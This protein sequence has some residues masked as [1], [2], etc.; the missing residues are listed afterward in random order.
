MDTHN[1]RPFKAN[2]KAKLRKLRLDKYNA[3]KAQAARDPLHKGRVA[4]PKITREEVVDAMLEAWEELDPNLGAN[5]WEVV[6][7][8]PYELAQEKGWTPKEAFADIRHLDWPWQMVSNIKPKDAGS[9][10]EAFEWDNV[11]ESN[12]E[13]TATP[14]QVRAQMQVNAVPDHQSEEGNQ[15]GS[16]QTETETIVVNSTS[17]L[18]TPSLPSQQSKKARTS[19]SSRKPAPIFNFAQPPKIP[20]SKEGCT[21]PDRLTSSRCQSCS[22]PV[23]G[24]CLHDRVLCTVCYNARMVQH[25]ATQK[26][27]RSASTAGSKLTG[28]SSKKLKMST[29]LSKGNTHNPP[30]TKSQGS[31]LPSATMLFT[32][33]RQQSTRD[34]LERAEQR[35]VQDALKASLQEVHGNPLSPVKCIPGEEPGFLS[36]YNR[37]LKSQGRTEITALDVDKLPAAVHSDGYGVLDNEEVQLIKVTREG[38]LR[39]MHSKRQA[40]LIAHLLG[41]KNIALLDLLERESN[42]R[43]C[44]INMNFRLFDLMT[45]LSYN[46]VT[47]SVITCYLHYLS[48]IH[49]NVYFVDPVL[50]KYVEEFSK[51]SLSRVENDWAL[52]EYVVWPLNLGNHHW[53]V[54]LFES[55]PGSTIYYVDSMNGTDAEQ[56]KQCIPPNLYHVIS[57]LGASLQPPRSWNPDIQ[58]ILVPRQQKQNNDCA[59]CVNEVARAFARDPKGFIA[60][61]ADLM[62]ESISLRCT[63]AATLLKWLY[64]D[65]CE[66]VGILYGVFVYKLASLEFQWCV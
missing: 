47:D 34:P 10:I 17:A 11:P 30:K 43:S 25:K 27:K 58:V 3:A 29:G 1:N 12:Y 24:N 63:Q 49:P 22:V 8:M 2:L 4:I 6:K 13:G 61:D 53:T 50:Y 28:P 41:S 51:S 5:A 31:T 48:S 37:V 7:L 40:P 42:I 33:R 64:H 54:A 52:H 59:A 57:V 38:Y 14:S 23:H 55:A 60:G 65:V 19:P 20:C 36:T 15:T 18:Q 32:P 62:F 46:F 44:E 9:D 35:M 66:N 16:S 45:L 56:Q 26:Q 39:L 21:A